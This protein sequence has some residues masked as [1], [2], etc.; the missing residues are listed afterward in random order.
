MRDITEKIT[1]NNNALLSL[2]LGKGQ[3]DVSLSLGNI[4]ELFEIFLDTHYADDIDLR[5]KMLNSV[6]VV[7]DLKKLIETTPKASFKKLEK[8]LYKTFQ[9]A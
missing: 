9:D 3:Q 7:R 8:K 5:Q 6:H 1:Q 4:N 2:L